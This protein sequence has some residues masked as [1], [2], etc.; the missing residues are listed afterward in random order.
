MGDNRE[1][2]RVAEPVVSFRQKG[3]RREVDIVIEDLFG[4]P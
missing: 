2:K 3:L 4:R 1:M